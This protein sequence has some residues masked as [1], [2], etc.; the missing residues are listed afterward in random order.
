MSRS[1]H[2]LA[3]NVSGIADGGDYLHNIPS[4]A[5]KFNVVQLLISGTSA[6]TFG[7]TLLGEVCQIMVMS[8]TKQG[9]CLECG[10]PLS[11]PNSFGY[12]PHC[13]DIAHDRANKEADEKFPFVVTGFD[14]VEIDRFKTKSEAEDFIFNIKNSD[15]EC[16]S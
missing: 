13:A 1:C 9:V 7:N 4:E 8:E 14:G 3:A 10:T 2:R 16:R 6:P 5:Q 12:H 15:I 11:N